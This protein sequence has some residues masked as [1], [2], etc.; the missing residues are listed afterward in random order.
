[1]VAGVSRPTLFRAVQRGELP[2]QSEPSQNGKL[3][4]LLSRHEVE[5]WSRLR[6]EAELP[7]VHKQETVEQREQ[8]LDAQ[9]ELIEQNGEPA[10]PSR[11]PSERS[12]EQVN[13]DYEPTMNIP[14]SVHLHLVNELRRMERESLSLAV[15][16]NRH[17]LAL[18]ENAESIIEREARARQ[19]EAIAEQNAEQLAQFERERAEL[20]ERMSTMETRV[21]WLEKRVPRWVRAMFGA[22]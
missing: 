20:I 9:W 14:V 5:R 19:A 7:H 6:Q 13:D 17:R 22:S 8:V 10:E 4:Y 18:T 1:M 12:H 21:N 15:E 11:V 2:A 3:R 16:L